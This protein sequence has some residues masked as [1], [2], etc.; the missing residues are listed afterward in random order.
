MRCHMIMKWVVPWIYGIAVI[1]PPIL[2]S[3]FVFVPPQV[4]AKPPP[5]PK[6]PLPTKP[7]QPCQDPLLGVP[8]Y[9]ERI[10]AIPSR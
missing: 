10:T 6:K 2:L 9:P 3:N 4:S 1:G 7:T 8:T 5:P